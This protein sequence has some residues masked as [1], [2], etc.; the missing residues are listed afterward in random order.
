MRTFLAN[1]SKLPSVGTTIFSVMSKL[2]QT[3]QAI[4]LSQGFPDYP[5]NPKLI[6][7]IHEALKNNYNQYAPMPGLP[8][9]LDEIAAL[10]KRV[11][12]FEANPENEITVTSGGTEALFNAITAIV[13]PEDEVIIFEPCYDSYVPAIELS[14]GIP[15]PISLN[16][17]TYTIDWEK[18]KKR[19]NQRTKAIII[20]SP[21]NPSGSIL[22]LSDI[23]ELSK[24]TSGT[25]IIII[26]DEVYEF[27][28]FDSERHESILRFPEL[29]ERSFVISSFGKSLH[30]TGWKIGYCV[31]PP[32][33][34]KEFRKV[35]QYVTFSTNTP[36]QWAIAQ[37]LHEN[38]DFYLHLSPFFQEK[39]DFFRNL[40]QN[41]RFELLPCSGTYF[42]LASYSQ[43]S[44]ESDVAFCERLTKEYG[45]AAI[46]LS[47][48]YKNNT[49]NHVI[50][51]CFAKKEETLIAAAEK[52]CKI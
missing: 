4:N 42:Q 47:V 34:T 21:H 51:F 24:L 10:I 29:R 12:G 19:I 52:L 16:P 27:F 40:M 7:L 33:L 15:V 5:V 22:Q 41:S 17:D 14:G 8:F 3:H 35:H 44:K 23:H 28:N 46:P 39:R 25:D 6:E 45:V 20:N 9:L 26:S 31:A 48:F 18:V 13:H 11:Y 32:N 2:A 1:S 37:Y 49:D 43:I 30:A 36:V 50:R 38:P